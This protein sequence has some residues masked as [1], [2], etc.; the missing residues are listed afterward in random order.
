LVLTD[1]GGIQEEAPSFGKPVLVLRET[2]ERPEGIQAGTARL[3]GTARD[4]IVAETERLLG[5]PASYARMA[6]AHNPYGDGRA[7]ERIAAH[8]ATHL[9]SRNRGSLT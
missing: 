7:G 9:A 4:R 6:V 5:D 8:L 3:V 2:T 1:S